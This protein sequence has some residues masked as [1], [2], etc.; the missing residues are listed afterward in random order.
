[1]MIVRVAM[2]ERAQQC[3]DSFDIILVVKCGWISLSSNLREG[4]KMWMWAVLLGSAS[5][6]MS[7]EYGVKG[8]R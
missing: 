7:K 1:M 6:S 3:G 4:R 5:L 2:T 8:M